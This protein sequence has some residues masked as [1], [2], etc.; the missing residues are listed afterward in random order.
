MPQS[1]TPEF[2]K[3]IVRLHLEEGRT[4]KSIT[5]EY[6]VSKA[7]I[8]KWCSEFSEEC[9]AKAD[10]NPNTLNEAE[11]MKEILRLRREL[12]ESRKENP[13]LKK[14]GGILC[15]GN[16][17]EAY[18]FIEEHH[19]LFGL[20]WLLRRLEICPNAYYNYRKH[21]KADYYARKAEVQ[22]QIQE[23]YH[24]HNGVDGYRSMKVYLERKGYSYSAVTVHKYMN[25]E[26]DLRSIVRPKKPGYEHGK[27]HKVFDNQLNQ[28]FTADEINRKWCTDFTYLF[29]ANHEVRY[30][31]TIIDL[32]DRSVI[33][34][35][36]DRNITSDL[37][38]RTLRKALESQ[39][40]IKEGLILHSDQGSQ[41]TSKAF[42]EFCKSV[43]VTQ[44]MSKAGYPYDN[45]PMERYFN[46]LKN[47]CTNL[48]EFT[49]EEALYQKVEEFAYVD[50]NHVRPHSF[51]GYRTPYEAR[52][53]A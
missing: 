51:N 22:A 36:T 14:S 25:T 20:R 49:T 21:R 43:H 1:Y 32:H 50:Y 24:A 11:L 27:P 23:I 45:A 6:G 31:C 52:M 12:E 13:F 26:L 18:R 42:I 19:K 44:S 4:Y 40:A 16:R 10:I 8:S 33:A 30:N 3:K 17:L 38:I 48:Y 41:Y 28:N 39:S 29:L 35:I 47:E 37:A 15:K 46:T 5:A 9:Q 7:S 2:K 53:A 34:S